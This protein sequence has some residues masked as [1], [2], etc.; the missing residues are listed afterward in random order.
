MYSGSI[1][2]YSHILW[3]SEF[4]CIK[5]WVNRRF[6]EILINTASLWW[7]WD[8]PTNRCESFC[9]K[10]LSFFTFQ[11]SIKL[12][13]KRSYNALFWKTFNFLVTSSTATS[14]HARCGD[15]F[16]MVSPDWCSDRIQVRTR[17]PKQPGMQSIPNSTN[18]SNRWQR[19]FKDSLIT[20]HTTFLM[21]IVNTEEE[22]H[23]YLSFP[24]KQS[25]EHM[26]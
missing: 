15:L 26:H 5:T 4:L 24:V 11:D 20:L 23:F 12:E 18:H 25:F 8:F 19:S 13:A 6:P 17:T 9:I 22:Q 3:I 7:D 10:C 14:W 16:N 1:L 21:S 2:I